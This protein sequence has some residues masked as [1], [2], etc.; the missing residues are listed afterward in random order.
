MKNL[1]KYA[2]YLMFF[3]SGWKIIEWFGLEET[4]KIIAPVTGRES[5][6]C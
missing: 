5:P 4:F 1:T 3:S 2:K 6:L